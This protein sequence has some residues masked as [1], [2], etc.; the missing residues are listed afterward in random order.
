MQQ[1]DVK[2]LRHWQIDQRDFALVDTLP[3]A[4]YDKGHLPGAIHIMS[5][6]ILDCAAA[7][8]PD[9]DRQVVVYCASVTCRRA[10][11]AA[12][13][14]ESLGYTRVIHFVGGKRDWIA[15]GFP[16]ERSTEE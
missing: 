10:G 12:G 13:R 14:L 5:D 9:T 2:T 4:A 8:L 16:L 3:G 1:I 6:D 11:L 15:A 7:R